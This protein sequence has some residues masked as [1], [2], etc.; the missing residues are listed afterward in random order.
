MRQ[1]AVCIASSEKCEPEA[2]LLE[3]FDLDHG[4]RLRFGAGSQLLPYSLTG[5]LSP[6][7]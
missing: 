1:G 5:A 4:G 6:P 2:E 7:D 3:R